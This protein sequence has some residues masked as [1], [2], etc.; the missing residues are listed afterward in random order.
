MKRKSYA[1]FFELNKVDPYA[2]PLRPTPPARYQACC[3][4]C[5]EVMSKATPICDDV[6]CEVC[7]KQSLHLVGS[8][9]PATPRSQRQF[10][11]EAL[12]S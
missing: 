2:S 4:A 8:P 12:D 1:A 6:L 7:R 5:G 11:G 10:D 9:Y 3:T